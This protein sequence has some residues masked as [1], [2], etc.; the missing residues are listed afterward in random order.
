ME[1]SMK[2]LIFA[3]LV[4]LSLLSLPFISAAQSDLSGTVTVSVEAWMVEKYN[5]PE[6][7]AMFEAAHPNVDVVVIT[8]EGLGANYLN[9][10]LEWA[11]TGQSTADL[12]FGGLVSQIAPAM[13]D[14]QLIPWDEMM[15]DELAPDKWFFRTLCRGEAEEVFTLMRFIR[16]WTMEKPHHHTTIRVTGF[17]H[18]KRSK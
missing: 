15:T 16:T 3:L 13:I 10:F 2:R 4:I 7:E 11:Q 5:M 17:R 18:R 8:H 6:L 14:D 1:K 12:Y 9:I